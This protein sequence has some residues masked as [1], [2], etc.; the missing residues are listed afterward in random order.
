MS[1]SYFAIALVH[2]TVFLK[3]SWLDLLNIFST[4]Q[5][6]LQQTLPFPSRHTEYKAQTHFDW[7]RS[8][9]L[10]LFSFLKPILFTFAASYP[11][12]HNNNPK[13]TCGQKRY[14]LHKH[15]D[16]NFSLG[17]LLILKLVGVLSLHKSTYKVAPVELL[18]IKNSDWIT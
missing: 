15:L 9:P 4:Q 3:H 5:S 7:S 8:Q 2:S 17:Q 13:S 14:I 12:L 10:R 1:L 18:Q 16:D 6:I 11:T